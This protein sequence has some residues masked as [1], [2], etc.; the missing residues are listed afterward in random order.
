[1]TTDSAKNPQSNPQSNPA[2]S[3]A[4]SSGR[5]DWPEVAIV[6]PVRNESRFIAETLTQII[7]QD[8]PAE[9]I[10][11]VIAD[12]H[13]TD[14]TVEIINEFKDRLP[15]LKVYANDKGG[16]GSGR[17][18]GIRETTAPY[19]IVIDGHVHI[20]SKTLLRDM[21]ETFERTRAFCLC[22][23]QPLDPPG[24]NLFQ[25][26]VAL[27]RGSLLG[28]NPSS[29]IYSD[30]EKET[31]P[32]SSGAMWRREVFD[33]LGNFD[34]DFDACEDV[35]L[36]FRVQQSGM[37]AWISPKLRVFYYPRSTV[38]GL[39]QQMFR[40]GVGRF[41][42][43]RKHNVKS[44]TQY[45]APLGVLAFVFFGLLSILGRNGPQEFTAFMFVGY[46]V[47]VLAT[48]GYISLQK[49]EFAYVFSLPVIFPIIHFG[50]GIGFIYEF[51]HEARHRHKSGQPLNPYE[52]VIVKT[53]A[54][55]VSPE[56]VTPTAAPTTEVA[57]K[58]NIE[59]EPQ[60]E[61]AS[62]ASPTTSQAPP[63]PP[64]PPDIPQPKPPTP[65][66]IPRQ[67]P[68]EA[69]KAQ[70]KSKPPSHQKPPSYPKPNDK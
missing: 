44:V 43:T 62:P 9:K 59:P 39:W 41:R 53:E 60:V 50:L 21:V 18:I 16:P 69:P 13:S 7:E 31:D 4:T 37:K 20:P 10:Q 5:T 34:E 22:R 45:L 65:P 32:T 68:P 64:S 35:D 2:S 66:D 58:S 38:R 27:A 19:I 30:V 24:I 23:P 17:N 15:Q 40:Y 70:E 6:M 8:Y 56:P 26:A 57:P 63:A 11:L 48:T 51:F 47:A 49:Q 61:P 42:F 55:P 67:A 3:P 25:E 46:L 33:K 28:H 36:N 29:D 12:G 1:M 54:P 52:K 14:G